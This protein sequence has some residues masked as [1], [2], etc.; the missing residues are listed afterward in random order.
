[1]CQQQVQAAIKG[2]LGSQGIVLAQQITH[3]TMGIPMPMQ[4]PLAARG[5]ESVGTEHLQNMF[6]VGAFPADP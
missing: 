2:V 3:R 6:P 5:N 1:M 4:M